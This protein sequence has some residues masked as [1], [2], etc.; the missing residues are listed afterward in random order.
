MKTLFQC[1]NRLFLLPIIIFYNIQIVFFKYFLLYT[2]LLKFL[3][4]QVD[5]SVRFTYHFSS[6][7]FPFLS[8]KILQLCRILI[9]IY[10][11]DDGE[12]N[13]FKNSARPCESLGRPGTI[14]LS[15]STILRMISD[16]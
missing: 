16:L 14:E 6:A 5:S 2:C 7:N 3:K 10:I 4:V 12:P 15:P 13:G 8:S 9:G 11:L 1:N